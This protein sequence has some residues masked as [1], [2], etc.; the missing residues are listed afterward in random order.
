MRVLI[1]DK[2]E[3]SGVDGLEH[4]GCEV[5][6][7]PDL[8]PETMP[9]AIEAFDADILI[10]RGTKVPAAV[11]EKAKKLSLVLRAGAGYDNIDVPAA[12]AGGMPGTL[13]VLGRGLTKCGDQCTQ[14][15]P[16]G[17]P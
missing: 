17:I 16:A 15:L 1:A 8:S 11:F 14:N 9:A 10:V 6:V 13:A 5:K 2:F 3:Q 4:A 12:Y 7:A